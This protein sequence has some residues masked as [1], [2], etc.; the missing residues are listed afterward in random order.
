MFISFFCYCSF[1]LEMLMDKEIFQILLTTSR[2][3]SQ[4]TRTFCNELARLIPK[5]IRVNRGKMSLDNLAEKALENNI[6]RVLIIEEWH[7]NP[8]KMA[9][10]KVLE[11]GLSWFPPK[12]IIRSL[13]LQREIK[14]SQVKTTK[15]Y[16]IL[17]SSE[18]AMSDVSKLTS[19]LSDFLQLPK[20]SHKD[21]G[22]LK[23]QNVVEISHFSHGCIK[24]TFTNFPKGV[25]L[26]PRIILSNLVWEL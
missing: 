24:I 20:L 12:M 18:G 2:H 9:L 16:G 5:C 15:V 4:R 10:F 22:C 3:P 19:V 13:T 1:G 6:A 21:V 8:G 25:E 17:E 26:G 7:G 23:N 14:R 11:S